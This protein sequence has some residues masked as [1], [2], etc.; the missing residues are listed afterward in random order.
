MKTKKFN[1]NWQSVLLG[2]MLSMM[3]VVFVGSNAQV[4]QA[5]A[6][7]G[8]IQRAVSMNELL[9]KSE[10]IDQRLLSVEKKIDRLVVGL[11]YL[12]KNMERVWREDKKQAAAK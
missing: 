9:A 12:L 11:D 10:L 4:S 5:N 3:L 6:Q 8:V 2:M 7:A 1:L